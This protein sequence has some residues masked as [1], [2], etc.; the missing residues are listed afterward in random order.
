[1]KFT[2]LT[3]FVFAALLGVSAQAQIITNYGNGTYNTGSGYP[4]LYSGSWNGTTGN[5]ISPGGYAAQTFSTGSATSLYAYNLQLNLSSASSNATFT[6]AVYS[7]STSNPNAGSGMKGTLVAGSVANFNL[8]NGTGFNPFGNN[9]ADAGG[10]TLLPNTVYAIVLQRTDSGAGSGSV[11]QYGYDVT[12]GSYQEADGVDF[13]LGDPGVTA[14]GNTNGSLGDYV[15]GGLYTSTNGT[16]FTRSGGAG[17]E[18]MAFWVSFSS[19]SLSPVPEPAVSGAI[20]G[21]L[22]VAGLVTVRR[23]RKPKAS[24]VPPA[25]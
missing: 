24:D 22:L 8:S 6:T 9:F 7:W 18:D 15:S 25:A 12:G 17:N 13:F 5:L 11:V 23:L 2:A 3:T 21:G 20:I 10:L 14:D 1:M 16:N 19:T 4:G